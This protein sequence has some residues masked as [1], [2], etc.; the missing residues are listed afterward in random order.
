MVTIS[1]TICF[2]NDWRKTTEVNLNERGVEL[3]ND[4]VEFLNENN[5]TFDDLK[6]WKQD[7]PEFVRES[8]FKAISEITKDDFTNQMKAIYCVL[9][10]ALNNFL[11]SE[12][13]YRNREAS[14]REEASV[15][16]DIEE[17]NA[18][19][20]WI[21]QIGRSLRG[22]GIVDNYIQDSSGKTHTIL[23]KTE[24]N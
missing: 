18:D 14:D 8:Y 4:L 11:R 5:L 20:K 17:D 2:V 9:N 13:E 16:I 23:V 6:K 24:L 1:H 22:L 21:G 15:Y 3:K 10:L 12:T 7:P 19:I